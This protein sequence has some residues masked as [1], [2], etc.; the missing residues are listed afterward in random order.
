MRRGTN[1]RAMGATMGWLLSVLLF[2]TAAQA[3][4]KWDWSQ[5]VNFQA[6][7]DPSVIWLT[8]G[9]RL[10]VH[11]GEI[12]WETVYHWSNGRA[13]LLAYR[14]ESGV[15]LVDLESG[16]T[17]PVLR[18]MDKAP[19]EI[20]TEKCIRDASTTM[21]IFECDVKGRDR[22]EQEVNR[23]YEALLGTLDDA[24]KNA[25]KDAQLEWTKF[26]DAQSFAFAAVNHHTGS[27]W[28]GVSAEQERRLVR[29]Q[30]ERLNDQFDPL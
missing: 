2:A 16:K 27:I 30:A 5:S 7:H 10:K 9:R 1:R 4:V 14:P 3:Q 8:D 13:L 12:P 17:I 11:Y 28:R 20:L 22:W 6:D 25:V 29:E 24:Q 19:I 15:V 23:A 18:G 26:R 21:G